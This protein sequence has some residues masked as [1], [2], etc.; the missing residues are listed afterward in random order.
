MPAQTPETAV[1]PRPDLHVVAGA[2]VMP[3]ARAAAVRTPRP[4]PSWAGLPWPWVS[5]DWL[6]ALSADAVADLDPSALALLSRQAC[7]GLTPA[8]I[9]ALSPVQAAALT[10]AD[11]LGEAAAAGWAAVMADRA[12]EPLAAEEFLASSACVA[13]ETSSSPVK[14]ALPPVLTLDAVVEAVVEGVMPATVDPADV[15]VED[16]AVAASDDD[17]LAGCL[18]PFD[19]LDALPEHTE[20]CALEPCASPADV[21]PCAAPAATEVAAEPQVRPLPVD[22]ATPRLEETSA[23]LDP[24]DLLASALD[25]LE[26]LET[27]DPAPQAPPLPLVDAFDAIAEPPSAV[28]LDDRLKPVVFHRGPRVRAGTVAD[29]RTNLSPRRPRSMA[30]RWRAMARPALRI[31]RAGTVLSILAGSR[32]PRGEESRNA[33]PPAR[34]RPMPGAD[35]PPRDSPAAANT[36][37]PPGPTG[38]AGVPSAAAPPD[39]SSA[40]PLTSWSFAISAGPGWYLPRGAPPGSLPGAPPGVPPASD[41]TAHGRRAVAGR[42]PPGTGRRR[43]RVAM[44]H[45]S[46]GLAGWARGSCWAAGPPAGGGHASLAV[47]PALPPPM[48]RTAANRHD[49]GPGP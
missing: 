3:Q 37:A 17:W 36:L 15:S 43:A 20:V 9:A 8:F 39:R 26:A 14:Q 46:P 12:A 30:A 11:A 34:A 44:V 4:D 32:G 25:A 5:A 19:A 47:T 2:G 6:N 21:D 1:H 7:G 38:R 28:R 27:L 33:A 49:G 41:P 45:G 48:R 35:A 40:R 42:A 22:P 13:E 24:G 10:H 16:I 31:A 18:D 29:D 23:D